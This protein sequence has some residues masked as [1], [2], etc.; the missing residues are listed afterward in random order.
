VVLWIHEKHLTE[1]DHYYV[2][3]EKKTITT[4]AFVVKKERGPQLAHSTHEDKK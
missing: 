2:Q 3:K 4:V 1:K